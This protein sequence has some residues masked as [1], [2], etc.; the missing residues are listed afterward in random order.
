MAPSR[1]IVEAHAHVMTLTLNR[2]EKLNAIDNE[3]VRE[4]LSALESAAADDRV[5][6]VLVL[7]RGRAF[8]AGQGWV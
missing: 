3:L 2:P 7:G 6:S 8:C 4:L 5:H 1:L